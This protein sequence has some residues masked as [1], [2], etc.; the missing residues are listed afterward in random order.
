MSEAHTSELPDLLDEV[1]KEPDYQ[2]FIALNIQV[3]E[4][5]GKRVYHRVTITSSF[6]DLEQDLSLVLPSRVRSHLRGESRAAISYQQSGHSVPS[7]NPNRDPYT[8]VC[9]CGQRDCEHIE[10]AV[11]HFQLIQRLSENVG[12]VSTLLR[13]SMRRSEEA[14]QVRKALESRLGLLE[15]ERDELAAR[16]KAEER[17]GKQVKE[18]RDELDAR[19]LEIIDLQT[20]V[21]RKSEEQELLQQQIEQHQRNYRAMAEEYWREKSVSSPSDV[22]QVS[23]EM[24]S[25]LTQHFALPWCDVDPK[26]KLQENVQADH[27]RVSNT[28]TVLTQLARI[29]FVR[30]LG[31]GRRRN[32][33]QGKVRID[34]KADRLELLVPHKGEADTVRIITTALSRPQQL[35][36]AYLIGEQFGVPVQDPS[37]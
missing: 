34:R 10:Y 13:E 27:H 24:L 25:V 6:R 1:A 3:P 21:G 14:E 5:K 16:V 15:Q 18:L 37:E 2:R 33:K 19:S 31:I 28:D 32:T 35:F 7:T 9:S 8:A 17:A 23:D 36:A 20:Q 12:R 22:G 26:D 29:E 4:V 30:E 11:E